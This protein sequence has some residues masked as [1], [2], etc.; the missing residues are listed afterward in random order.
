[1]F[2]FKLKSIVETLT[3]R[4]GRI[5]DFSRKNSDNIKITSAVDVRDINTSQQIV[6]LNLNL[7][8]D[9]TQISKVIQMFTSS[10]GGNLPEPLKAQ[11][12]NAIKPFE[13]KLIEDLTSSASPD[14]GKNLSQIDNLFS[15]SEGAKLATLTKQDEVKILLGKLVA[16]KIVSDPQSSKLQ[17]VLNTSAL[18]IAGKLTGE[19]LRILS[20]ALL[21]RWVFP[22]GTHTWGEIL[23]ILDDDRLWEIDMLTIAEN[24]S[25][26]ASAGTGYQSVHQ[27]LYSATWDLR[28]RLFPDQGDMDIIQ[29]FIF[30]KDRLNRDLKNSAKLFSI[31]EFFQLGQFFMHTVGSIITASFLEQLIGLSIEAKSDS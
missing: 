16:S 5:F 26:M 6:N 18:S 14:L 30:I 23:A 31:L 27:W 1:M 13:S 8:N 19:Q 12:Q 24:I 22:R 3:L 28:K 11:I 29:S 2:D 21:L 9:P 4:I 20:L 17:N 7:G 25:Y 15:I 10:L